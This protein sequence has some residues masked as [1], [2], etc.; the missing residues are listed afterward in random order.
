MTRNDRKRTKNAGSGKEPWRR[1]KTGTAADTA[2]SLIAMAVL[3]IVLIS[4]VRLIQENAKVINFAAWSEAARPWRAGTRPGG[5]RGKSRLTN[6]GTAAIL[7]IVRYRGG[8]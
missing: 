6:A 1:E 5:G 7:N 8:A 3:L 4:N 2:F